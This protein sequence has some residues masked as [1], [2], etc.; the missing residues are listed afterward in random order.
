MFHDQE[1]PVVGRSIGGLSVPNGS[2]LVFA[3]EGWRGGRVEQVA[4]EEK[5]H[6]PGKV[7]KSVIFSAISLSWCVGSGLTG[8]P[9]LGEHELEQGLSL[10]SPPI[11][12]HHLHPERFM[13][14]IEEARREWT[15]RGAKIDM[16]S[17]ASRCRR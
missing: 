3:R 11:L 14:R 17:V 10:S 8:P 6:W 9:G 4:T 15:G 7:F 12:A 5:K 1:R 13:E 2:Y 16:N